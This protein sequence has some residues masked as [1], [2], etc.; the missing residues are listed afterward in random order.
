LFEICKIPDTLAIPDGERKIEARLLSGGTVFAHLV[1]FFLISFDTFRGGG[2]SCAGKQKG[3]PHGP[4]N[5]SQ[6]GTK[7]IKFAPVT[8]FSL[9][10]VYPLAE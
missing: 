6:F 8:P 2:A 4:P 10:P 7:K 9:L 1:G 5:F 3:R